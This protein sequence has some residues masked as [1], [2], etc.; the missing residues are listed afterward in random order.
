MKDKRAIVVGAG[1]G[2]LSAAAYLAKSGLKVD[3]F[4]R[5][6]YPGGYACSFVRGQYEFEASLHEL[7]GIGPPDNRGGCYR[8]LEGCDVARRVEF[9][10]IDDFYS[11]IFP[12]FTVKV[13]HGWAA[14]EEAYCSRFPQERKGISRVLRAM[15]KIYDA[16]SEASRISKPSDA[17]ALPFKAGDLVRSLGIT[18]AQ[19]L[20]REMADPRLKALFTNIWGYYGLPPSRLSWMLFA[21]AN[22]S[23]FEHGPYHVKGTTQA[24]SNAFVESIEEN[25]GRVH[26]RNGVTRIEVADGRATGVVTEQGGKH[27]ADFVVCNANPITTCFKLIGAENVPA[28]YLKALAGRHIA[29]STF[30]VYMGLD[31]P[32]RDLGLDSHEMFINEGYDDDEHY[33]KMFTTERPSYWVVTNY[34]HA[35]HDFSPPGTSVVVLTTLMDYTAWAHLPADRYRET[36]D[37]LAHEMIE[38]TDRHFP[39]LKDHIALAEVSTPITNMRYSGNPG[40]SILGFDYD[41]A[42]SPPFRLSNRGPLERL[43]FANAWVRMGGGMETCITS[44]MFAFGEVMKDLRGTKGLARLL[45]ATG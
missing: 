21:V 38:A 15:R 8:V 7:S 37:R 45:P 43:Y 2:G 32:A 31:C 10:P 3:V 29:V 42:G 27:Q 12:D 41:V 13:P 17:L 22:A 23:Y 39:G 6:S 33:L 24:L 34:N 25:G 5:N 9:L 30:N 16:T 44:G 26:L 40:G 1:L 36:K 14:A 28:D 19:A 18:T 11:S 35:D 4:E 20:D